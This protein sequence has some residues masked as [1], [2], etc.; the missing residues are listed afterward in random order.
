LSTALTVQPTL[1]LT[2]SLP[3]L[4]QE[5]SALR[6]QQAA[7]RLDLNSLRQDNQLLFSETLSLRHQQAVQQGTLDKMLRFLASVFAS[8]KGLQ[9]AAAAAGVSPASLAAAAASLTQSNPSCQEGSSSPMKRP[10]LMIEA[11]PSALKRSRD[12]LIAEVLPELDEYLNPRLDEALSTS[13]AMQQDLNQLDSLGLDNLVDEL[14]QDHYL[15]EL[16]NLPPSSSPGK[17]M[18]RPD[19][20]APEKQGK[21]GGRSKRKFLL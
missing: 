12:P 1:S 9:A 17:T 16:L 21:E 19:N 2:Q 18:L 3:S 14:D 7:L 15:D 8:D 20:A 4:L 10:S 11:G 13:E 6:S 5:M